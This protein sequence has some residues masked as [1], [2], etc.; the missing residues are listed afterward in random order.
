VQIQRKDVEKGVFD[1]QY[2]N[3][4][5]REYSLIDLKE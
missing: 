5:K 4:I 3:K 1:N 2:K